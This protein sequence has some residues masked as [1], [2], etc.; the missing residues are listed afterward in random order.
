MSDKE[1]LT[2]D[3]AYT[4]WM[5]HNSIVLTENALFS[6]EE[7]K[8]ELTLQIP[9]DELLIKEVRVKYN[10]PR[11]IWNHPITLHIYPEE[12]KHFERA[13]LKLEIDDNRSL[14]HIDD[15]VEFLNSIKCYKWLK[16]IL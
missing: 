5:I 8:F 16:G 7:K 12:R 13:I 10:P 4:P 9:K 6:N 14:Y 1:Y 3:E 15:I 11:N 2:Y